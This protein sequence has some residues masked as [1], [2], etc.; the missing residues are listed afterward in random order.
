MKK[1]RHEQDAKSKTMQ[2]E[3]MKNIASGFRD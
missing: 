1:T 3:R 2:E